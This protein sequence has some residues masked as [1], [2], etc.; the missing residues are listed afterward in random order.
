MFNFTFKIAFGMFKFKFTQR[1]V[2]HYPTPSKAFHPLA[3][4]N[5]LL[6]NFVIFGFL[7]FRDGLFHDCSF[8]ASIN[9]V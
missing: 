6:Q 7:L 3:A 9:L 4:G 8:L 2:F 1:Q 5:G